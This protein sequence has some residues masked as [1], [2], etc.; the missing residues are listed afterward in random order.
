M[1]PLPFLFLLALPSASASPALPA[2][3]RLPLLA[4]ARRLQDYRNVRGRFPTTYEGLAV[5]ARRDPSERVARDFWKRTFHYES[6]GEHFL[7]RSYGR[8]GAP[9]GTGEDA[10]LTLTDADIQT[11]E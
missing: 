4:A 11:P 5:L 10:D 6:D 2:K 7:L 1:N 3:A 9:G 8:D